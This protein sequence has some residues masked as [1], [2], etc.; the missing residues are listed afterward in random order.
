MYYKYIGN[1]YKKEISLDKEAEKLIAYRNLSK[2]NNNKYLKLWEISEFT[3]YILTYDVRYNL[4]AYTL[5]LYLN[6]NV[7]I[8]IKAITK[9]EHDNNIP[10][11]DESFRCIGFNSYCRFLTPEIEQ[12]D[13][14]RLFILN[15]ELEQDRL[16]R[17]DKNKACL[18][19]KIYTI[20]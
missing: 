2:L 6:N 12:L 17:C 16:D 19:R 4:R 1:L 9:K 13:S 20:R 3:D 8:L 11:M 14:A 15:K 18:H 5:Y 10:I 7:R